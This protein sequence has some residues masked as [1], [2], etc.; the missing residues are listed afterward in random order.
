MQEINIGLRYAA[1][2]GYEYAL[3]ANPDMEFPQRG[4]CG[5]DGGKDGRG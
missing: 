2:K 3:I 4:L 1:N 5:K